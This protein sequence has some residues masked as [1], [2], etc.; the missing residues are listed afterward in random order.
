MRSVVGISPGTPLP[1]L[2]DQDDLETPGE[3]D[4]LLPPDPPPDPPM[5]EP[6]TWWAF[7]YPNYGRPDRTLFVHISELNGK[8]Q[9]TLYFVNGD[10][11]TIPLDSWSWSAHIPLVYV[12]V[13]AYEQKDRAWQ[14]LASESVSRVQPKP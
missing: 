12:R 4:F 14:P 11:K 1:S 10:T 6:G 13:T 7:R 5:P 3:H 2:W 9:K 8:L